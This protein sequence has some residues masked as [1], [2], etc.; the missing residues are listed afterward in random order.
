VKTNQMKKGEIVMKKWLLV[1]SLLM[2][3][4]LSA[5]AHGGEHHAV[6]QTQS[7]VGVFVNGISLKTVVNNNKAYVS[8]HDFAALFGETASVNQA[9]QTAEW[10]G[11][12]ISLENAFKGEAYA[13]IRDL[14]HAAEATKVTWNPEEK[15]VYVLILPQGTVQLDPVVIP[16]MGEH[17]GNPIDMPTGPIYG[18]FEGK[19]VFI[20]YM[21]SQK[22]F[23]EGKSYVNLPGMKGLPL[24][25][26]YNPTL[27][28]CPTDI[29]ALKC[30]TLTCIIISLQMKSSKK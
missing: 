3:I 1:F 27:I 9:N 17:W 20:E 12:V 18:V 6:Q 22:D 21:I 13:W 5:T 7:E 2:S 29:L 19:L 14:A 23:A 30:R 10:N 15:S 11:K 16:A 25:P 26:L 24:Q 8:V 28:L 4:P